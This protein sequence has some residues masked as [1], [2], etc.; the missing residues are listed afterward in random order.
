[1]PTRGSRKAVWDALEIE[2]DEDGDVVVLAPTE[3]LADEVRLPDG[4]MLGWEVEE[5]AE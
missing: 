4:R 1:M 5:A 3:R 2:T